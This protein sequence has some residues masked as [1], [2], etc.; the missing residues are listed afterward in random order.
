MKS[1]EAHA[2]GK[3][4]NGKLVPGGGWDEADE[5]QPAAKPK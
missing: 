5:G 4:V 1:A 2:Q 3:T